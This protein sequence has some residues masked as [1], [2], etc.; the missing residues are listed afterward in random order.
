MANEIEEKLKTLGIELPP[1]VTPGAN[2]IPGVITGK[3]VF[4]SGQL[5]IAADG[6]VKF[7]GKVGRELTVEDGQKAAR[8]CAVNILG[9]LQATIGDLGKLGRIVKLTGFVN[10]VPDFTEPQFVVNGASDL[11]V[12]VLG[13]AAANVVSFKTVDSRHESPANPVS[14]AV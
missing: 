3:L 14:C 5:P 7:V 8:M 11:L 9:A 10:A 6:T 13:N 1:P 4:I 12:E 2:Y